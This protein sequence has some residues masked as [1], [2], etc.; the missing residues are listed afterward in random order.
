MRKSQIIGTGYY[1]PGK[2]VTNFDLMKIMDTSDEWITTKIGIKER[3]IAAED[4][5]TSDMAA[6]AAKKAMKNANITADDID[7]I[8]LATNFPDHIS[9]ATSVAIQKK[10]GAKNAF[11]FDIRTGGC[12]GSVFSLSIASKYIADGTCKTILVATADINSKG[13]DWEDRSTAVIFGD[14]A[15]AIILKSV[16][17]TEAGIIDSKLYTDPEGYYAAYIPA[18]G[19]AEPI[20]EQAIKEKRQYFRMD[21]R[22]IFD[23]ATKAFPDAV[24]EIVKKNKMTLSDIDFVISHQA[25]LNIIR[26]SMENLGIPME[27]TYYNIHKYGNTSSASVGIALAEAIENGV[28]KKG[29]K[30]VLVSFGAGT[31]WGTVLLEL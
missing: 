1:V 28:I 16:D 13:L 11:A 24:K 23:F 8:L 20:T 2:I 6:E 27:K 30:V 17:E 4:E 7:M 3:R 31:A 21:G 29:D 14:G 19:V 22:A 26:Q 18:G 15:A 12:P 5:L 9:P 25:N 10:I